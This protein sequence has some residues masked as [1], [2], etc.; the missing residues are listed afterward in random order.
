[1]KTVITALWLCVCANQ[2]SCILHPCLTAVQMSIVKSLAEVQRNTY[3][4]TNTDEKT[5]A[6][7]VKAFRF[8]PFSELTQVRGGTFITPMEKIL[9]DLIIEKELRH[10]S[11]FLKNMR[12]S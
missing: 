10:S 1:M 8:A 12:Q 3:M 11:Y 5:F 9:P 2:S 4:R 6:K 7:G